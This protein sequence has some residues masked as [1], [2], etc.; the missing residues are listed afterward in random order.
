MKKY[1]YFIFISILSTNLLAQES[2]FKLFIKGGI[3]DYAAAHGIQV[4]GST[5]SGEWEIGPILGLGT[6]YTLGKDWFIQGT[7]EYS[8]NIYDAPVAASE[9]IESGSNTVIDIMGNIKK[10]WDWFYLL[11]GIG[12][13]SQNSSDSYIYGT[14]SNGESYRY[15]TYEGTSSK[16]FTGLLGIGLEY[17]FFP[18]IGFFLEGSWRFRNYVTP[19]A[20]LGIS[21]KI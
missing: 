9:T 6:E 20:Q 5:G 4:S 2:K 8:Y 12:F 14:S 15:L 16:V 13:S 19:A 1:Y 3:S 11:A 10:R 18:R 7:F 17:Y 21:Y